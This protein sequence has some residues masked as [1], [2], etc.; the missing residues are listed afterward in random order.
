MI[1]R[2]LGAYYGVHLMYA[3]AASGWLP[4][5]VA[6]GAAVAAGGSAWYAR[7]A[8]EREHWPFVWPEYCLLPIDDKGNELGDGAAF[9]PREGEYKLAVR[10]HNDGPGLAL[11]VAWTIARRSTSRR[12][13]VQPDNRALNPLRRRKVQR[14]IHS[15]VQH[16]GIARK[17]PG[18]RA[19][20]SGEANPEADGVWLREELG[21]QYMKDVPPS[22]FI[23]VRYSDVAGRRWEYP[24]RLSSA[25]ELAPPPRRVRRHLRRKL[26]GDRSHWRYGWDW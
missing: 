13:K 17:V 11:D 7:T 22:H 15:A 21:D 2:R 19:L 26:E 9:D 20:R 18:G 25:R 1:A 24:E 8:L 4:T 10:L 14:L 3:D 6:V 5:A 12:R 16:V 23:V